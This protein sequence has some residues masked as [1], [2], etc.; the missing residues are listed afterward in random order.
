[1]EET[2]ILRFDGCLRERSFL[3]FAQHRAGRLSVGL[4][5]LDLGPRAARMAVSGPPELVDA[6]EMALGLGPG[7]CLVREVTRESGGPAAPRAERAR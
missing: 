2:A 6:F 1:M 5:V 4:R 7:D 3:E